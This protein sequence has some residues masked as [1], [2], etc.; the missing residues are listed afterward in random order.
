MA[1]P[2]KKISLV[3][4]TAIA[5][6]A[7]DQPASPVAETP[8]T[9]APKTETT[10][11]A[12]ASTPVTA[13]ILVGTDSAYPPYNFRNEKGQSIGFDIDILTAIGAKQGLKFNFIPDQ[14]ELVLPNLDRQKY[15]VAISG[16]VRNAEREQ[17]YQVSNT[18]AYG[19]DVIVSLSTTNPTPETMAD[20][21]TRK[22][23]ILGGSYYVEQMENAVGKG[24]PN[25]IHAKNSFLVMKQV[26][27]GDAEAA[28]MDKGVAQ[29]Y[30]KSFSNMKFNFTGK[31]SADFDKYE[32]VILADKAEAELMQKINAGLAQI[33][34]DKTY[35]KIYQNW[36]GEEPK[37]VPSAK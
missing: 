33:V 17:K 31:G 35:H 27:T 1:F 18:Y 4:A 32:M 15:K 12:S 3:L 37:D 34:Q 9:E 6:S 19:Q 26:A 29:H 14:A 2:I 13:E 24:N 16:F 7:C 20:L 25:L 30:A 36:F 8:K 10:P 11:A 5:L 21:K 22:T 28:F 23:A